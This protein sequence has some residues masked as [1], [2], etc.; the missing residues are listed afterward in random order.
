MKRRTVVSREGRAETSIF[1]RQGLPPPRKV[2]G[3]MPRAMSVSLLD[4]K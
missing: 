1:T 4:N 2:A 3:G